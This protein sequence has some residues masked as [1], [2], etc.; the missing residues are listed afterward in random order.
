MFM[1]TFEGDI[2]NDFLVR[3]ERRKKNKWIFRTIFERRFS[4]FGALF[5][6]AGSVRLGRGEMPTGSSHGPRRSIPICG[7]LVRGWFRPA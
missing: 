2:L 4:D 5:E 1:P 3:E 7:S 6:K